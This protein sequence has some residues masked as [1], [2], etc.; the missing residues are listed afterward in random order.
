MPKNT[1]RTILTI[2]PATGWMTVF[3][4]KASGKLLT[5]P[6]ACWALVEE[7]DDRWVVGMENAGEQIDFSEYANHVGYLGPGE[8]L[9]D[10][11]GDREKAFPAESAAEGTM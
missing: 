8:S 7:D 6:L 10:M 3:R 4:D 1:G 2:I 9:H 5:S 11:F